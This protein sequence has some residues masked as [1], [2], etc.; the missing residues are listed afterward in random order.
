MGRSCTSWGVWV[1]F[2]EAPC[3]LPLGWASPGP[4]AALAGSSC[5][6]C[7]TTLCTALNFCGLGWNS[8]IFTRCR[9][10]SRLMSKAVFH[11]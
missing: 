5:P 8:V 6:G 10:E 2:R 11:H 9:N 4:Q 3:S 7:A 1:T